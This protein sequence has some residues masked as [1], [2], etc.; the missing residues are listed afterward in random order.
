M[1]APFEGWVSASRGGAAVF[2]ALA[3]A[4]TAALASAGSALGRAWS[5]A[6]A[7]FAEVFRRQAMTLVPLALAMWA[8]HF[9]YHLATAGPSVVPVLYRAVALPME[10]G[11]GAFLGPAAVSAIEILL[12]DG[13]LLLTLYAGWRLAAEL[14]RERPLRL[15]APLALV[16]A[17]LWAAGAWTLLQPMAMR[18]M[19]H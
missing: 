16:A 11:P 3:L 5:G 19:L 7:G 15:F 17:A 14:S 8:A 18:G 12:L 9:F 4:A 6:P 2:F 13:G 1:V 10:V